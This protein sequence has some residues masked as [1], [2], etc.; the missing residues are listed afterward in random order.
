[1]AK[2]LLIA[3]LAVGLA[4]GALGFALRPRHRSYASHGSSVPEVLKVPAVP[5][6]IARPD[7]NDENLR[8]SR[9]QLLD[10]SSTRKH[11]LRGYS[12]ACLRFG[13][14]RDDGLAVRRFTTAIL[15]DC[16]DEFFLYLLSEVLP[17]SVERNDAIRDRCVRLL[18]QRGDPR[19]VYACG[20]YLA[21]YYPT[22]YS[23][24]AV[25]AMIKAIQSCQ[26]ADRWRGT[27]LRFVA[28]NATEQDASNLIH[29]AKQDWNELRS[30]GDRS[31]RVRI[32]A[33]LTMRLEPAP[34][35]TV[36]L[37]R[38][39]R[40]LARA[41]DD[42]L[43]RTDIWREAITAVRALRRADVGFTREYVNTLRIEVENLRLVVVASGPHGKLDSNPIDE[44]L[45]DL[46]TR[47]NH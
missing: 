17:G 22:E 40:E 44:V 35:A 21:G 19:S 11:R 47:A 38:E 13:K 34:A 24:L 30:S 7:P 33:R 32:I 2:R 4:S 14:S 25:Q 42:P 37:M 23:N 6:E 46:E 10:A 39:L 18:A 9:G 20:R 45:K 28:H 16:D 15:L 12:D 5:H 41:F 31:E 3:L 1:M 43:V 29:L 27:L 26:P 36:R 8:A